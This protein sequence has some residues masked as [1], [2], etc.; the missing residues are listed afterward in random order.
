MAAFS[1]SSFISIILCATKKFDFW[2]TTDFDIEIQKKI[3]FEATYIDIFMIVNTIIGVI[4]G[5]LH[6]IP[7]EDDADIYYPLY[8]FE[9]FAPE[10]LKD[11]LSWLYRSS[12]I[13]T[14]FVMLAPLHIFQTCYDFKICYS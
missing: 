7:L 2:D 12:F 4:S 1:T 8:I 13:L 9:E 5:V 6:S 11:V 10:S 3:K 14:P